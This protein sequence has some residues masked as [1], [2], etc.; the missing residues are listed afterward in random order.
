MK[1]TGTEV[2]MLLQYYMHITLTGTSD[3]QCFCRPVMRNMFYLADSIRLDS[4]KGLDVKAE[5]L[6]KILRLGQ[7]D[8]VIATI[9]EAGS[10]YRMEGAKVT[11]KS[12]DGDNQ[13]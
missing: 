8:T 5:P 3:Q 11:L 4:C 9:T 10:G 6:N 13:S 7:A 2:K 1:P 12:E